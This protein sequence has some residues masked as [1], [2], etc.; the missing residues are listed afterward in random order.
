MFCPNCRTQVRETDNFCFHCGRALKDKTASPTNVQY[1]NC[2]LTPRRVKAVGL[3][4][5]GSDQW[6]FEAISVEQ[7]GVIVAASRTFPI[8]S[9]P[10]T[11]MEREFPRK[12]TE[13]LEELSSKLISEGWES[14]SAG[15]HGGMRRF[16]RV[17]RY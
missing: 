3:F 13:A 12:A 10:S 15:A 9:S 17:V 6:I 16:R 1:E 14:T 2:V 11:W 4:S 7:P 8:W 5:L